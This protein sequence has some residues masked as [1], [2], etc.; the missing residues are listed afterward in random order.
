MNC[1]LLS[2]AFVCSAQH[3]TLHGI[4]IGMDGKPIQASVGS[5]LKLSSKAPVAQIGYGQQPL[6]T[7]SQGNF[8]ISE[9]ELYSHRVVAVDSAGNVGFGA[10]VGGSATIKVFLHQPR[11]LK[12]HL[13]NPGHAKDPIC[14]IDIASSGGVLG[15]AVG[16]WGDQD[17]QIPAGGLE[18]MVSN[19]QC[20]LA[21]V[22][23]GSSPRL[24]IR[25]EA[26]AWAVLIGKQA[27]AITPT[28]VSN[29]EGSFDLKRLRGKW[30]LVDFWAVWCQP[31]VAEMDGI[32]EFYRTNKDRNSKF[33]IL[34]IHSP[35]GK[36]A[37]SLAKSLE[38][39]EKS[40][41]HGKPLPFSVVVRW[42]R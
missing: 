23:V 25:L 9:D 29:W 7:D 41:W 16:S 10:V 13:E 17:L 30:V 2:F 26:T 8:T 1:L 3:R 5:S 35:D 36:N 11:L 34:A 31:C 37:A 28:S 15:Y 38:A 27:P 6:Q 32:A 14:S 22:N 20:R 40:Y 24:N 21:T 42:Q 12:L 33:E 39:L 19:S 18:V 4:V